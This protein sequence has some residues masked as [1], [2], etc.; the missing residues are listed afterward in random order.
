VPAHAERADAHTAQRPDADEHGGERY[1]NGDSSGTGIWLVI[2]AF[3][4]IIVGLFYAEHFRVT[5]DVDAKLAVFSTGPAIRNVPRALFCET[6][7]TFFLVFPVFLITSASVKLP[8]TTG[9]VV[10]AP[11]GLG[12]LGALPVALLVLG[13]GLALGGTTG[14][15]INPA[16][17]LGPRLVLALLPVPGKATSDWPYAW[18]PVI[19]PVIGG[20]L[21]A[22]VYSLTKG[23]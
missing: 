23:I 1:A 7:A 10:D 5:D 19:G 21:A 6:V 12:S 8:G 11:V 22:G 20:L 16:R 2:A 18:V 3:V 14:Y 13:L 4:V 9:S 17:D 15:A